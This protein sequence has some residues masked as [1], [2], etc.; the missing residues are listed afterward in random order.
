MEEIKMATQDSSHTSSA[1]EQS[2]TCRSLILRDEVG[3]VAIG[4]RWF[5]YLC[6]ERGLDGSQLYPQLVKQYDAPRMKP[7]FNEA[8]R[9][10][11]GFT[12]DKI[13]FLLGVD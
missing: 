5:H 7:P 1:T 3:H 8:A 9:K 11:A 10:A 2:R 6:K 13:A 4:N 12:D